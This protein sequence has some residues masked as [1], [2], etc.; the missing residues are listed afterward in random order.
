MQSL[1]ESCNESLGTLNHSLSEKSISAV[2]RSVDKTS[3]RYI[4][5][6]TCV[7]VKL[8]KI[9]KDSQL[10]N[11]MRFK[12]RNRC[13]AL[14]VYL[15]SADRLFFKCLCLFSCL[16]LVP[17]HALLKAVEYIANFSLFIKKHF[18]LIEGKEYVSNRCTFCFCRY[19]VT[20]EAYMS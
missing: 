2:C 20:L 8:L 11:I 12:F 10:I 3:P 4:F 14:D 7:S 15:L 5:T 13:S 19:S 9:L 17:S 16:C 1:S 6:V 18:S